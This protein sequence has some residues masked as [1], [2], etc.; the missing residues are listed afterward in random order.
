MNHQGCVKS[1]HPPHW[2]C[3]K[4]ETSVY[5]IYINCTNSSG[6]H[7]LSHNNNICISTIVFIG[8]ELQCFA[9]RFVVGI[10][11]VFT[12]GGRSTRGIVG[13]PPR[14]DSGANTDCR[15]VLFLYRYHAMEALF[16]CDGFRSHVFQTSNERP[17]SLA[18]YT[19]SSYSSSDCVYC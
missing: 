3:R 12:T 6:P 18:V 15:Y 4:Q 5:N 16:A 1:Q 17:H 7:R 11:N 19:F 14:L 13:T 10:Q 8:L 9:A 2:R